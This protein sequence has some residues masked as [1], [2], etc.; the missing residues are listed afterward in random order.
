MTCHIVLYL[1]HKWAVGAGISE[2]RIDYSK[3]YQIYYQQRGNTIIVLLC[4]GHKG[5]QDSD[6]KLAKK[7]AK[8]V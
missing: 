5:T 8:E 3:G 1:Y 6:I 7:L 4:G 2:L